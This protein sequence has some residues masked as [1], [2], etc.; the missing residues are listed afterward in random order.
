MLMADTL[1]HEPLEIESWVLLLNLPRHAQRSEIDSV[2]V[3]LPDAA[4]RTANS[5]GDAFAVNLRLILNTRVHKS[6][7][8]AKLT[9]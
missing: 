8:S 9:V 5:H 7:R 4:V 3:L 6:P 2:A 1:F